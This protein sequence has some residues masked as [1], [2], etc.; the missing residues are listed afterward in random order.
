M[1]LR[2]FSAV[3]WRF[4][5]LVLGG[6]LLATGLALYAYHSRSTSQTWQSHAQLIITQESFPYGR[7]VQQYTGGSVKTG[8]PP[9]P[10]GNQTYMSSL[11]PIY[12]ALANGNSIQQSIRRQ[13]PVPGAVS[14]SAVID[15]ATSTDLPFVQLTATAPS[16][17]AAS[18]LAVAATSVLTQYVEQQQN[19][20]G[21]AASDRVL[22]APVQ[23]GESARLISQQKITTP[24]LVFVAIVCAT[25][26]L[27]FVLENARPR[28]AVALG[29]VPAIGLAAAGDA[30]APRV[31][32][33]E[34]SR[35]GLASTRE[36]EVLEMATQGL[37]NAEIARHLKV[38]SYSVKFHL[39]SVYRKLG[40]ANRTEA[41]AA[42]LR[43]EGKE[44]G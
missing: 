3:V 25:L 20:A 39:S 13:A 27:A 2:L 9:S 11:S 14:A 28:T 34:E 36:R 17:S 10:V 26:G 12:A 21:I 18:R 43:A 6:V 15:P 16:R 33:P 40:V 5:W 35:L 24:L 4:K 41:V 23:N 29:K 1:D 31:Q 19:S 37:T 7:A 38:T 8:V 44:A 42:Y 22:L 30:A 32:I